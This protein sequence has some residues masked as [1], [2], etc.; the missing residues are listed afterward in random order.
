LLLIL[1]IVGNVSALLSGYQEVHMASCI[2][3]FRC[4]TWSCQ[5]CCKCHSNDCWWL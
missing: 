2:A 1:L 3:V 5:L 4:F